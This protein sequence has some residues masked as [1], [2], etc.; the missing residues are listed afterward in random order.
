MEWENKGIYK[1]ETHIKK[2]YI[3]KKDTYK[4]Q[5]QGHIWK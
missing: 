1:D 2:R 3:R 5:E 4:V